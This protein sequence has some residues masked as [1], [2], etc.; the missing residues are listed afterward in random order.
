MEVAKGGGAVRGGE[1]ALW[2]LR[3]GRTNPARKPT[4]VSLLA[5]GN[6]LFEFIDVDHIDRAATDRLGSHLCASDV[7]VTIA[8]G[9]MSVGLFE[10]FD[11]VRGVGETA[12]Q[13]HLRDRFVGRDEQQSRV[14]QSLLDEPAVGRL[15]EMFLELL[16]ERGE[17]AVAH[18]RQLLDRNVLE[19]VCI[20][21]LLEALLAR[22]GV[23]H[24]LALDAVILLR[25]NQIDQLG[26]FQILGRFVVV[27]QLV[28]DVVIGCQEEVAQGTCRLADH[29][30]L[31]A[32]RRTRVVVRDVQMVGD[33]Q[34]R[35]YR[36]Q[37]RRRVVEHNLLERAV[38]FGLILDVVVA[39]GE[40]KQI[41]TPDLLAHVAR[42]DIL[43]AAQHHSDPVPREVVGLDTVVERLRILCDYGL[44]HSRREVV[45]HRNDFLA[46]KTIA[47]AIESNGP[48]SATQSSFGVC[49]SKCTR[50]CR[51]NQKIGK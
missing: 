2:G 51:A 18:S 31:L 23:V 26:H 32:A 8:D 3:E 35:E 45:C 7:A 42:I 46:D 1:E 44:L 5:N 10:E 48:Q 39:R 22:V 17:R 47:S 38:C 30:I 40:E 50:N 21:D 16:F 37:L 13:A 43:F 28:F 9:R 34:L 20:D 24:H 12:L 49:S 41:A 29:E 36:G 19:D 4:P 27:E 25:H 11:E 6:L 14:H 33:A 15:D